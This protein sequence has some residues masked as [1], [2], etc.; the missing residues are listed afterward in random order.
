ML[1]L[2]AWALLGLIAG[3][4]ADLIV[5]GKAPGGLIGSMLVGIVGAVFGGFI[6]QLLGGPGLAGPLTLTSLIIAVLGAVVLLY[7]LRALSRTT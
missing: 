5:P 1:N 6:F 3:W 7:L 4:I 2:L